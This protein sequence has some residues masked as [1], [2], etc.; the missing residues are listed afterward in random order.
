[1]NNKIE[2]TASIPP[3]QSAINTGSDG[4]RIKL[5]IPETDIS[6]AIRLITLRGKAFK[7]TVEE[8]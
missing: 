8:I 7:V 3:I 2:F 6:Q 5:D 4:M 1:M